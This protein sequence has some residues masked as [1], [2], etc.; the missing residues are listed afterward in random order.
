MNKLMPSTDFEAPP[1]GRAK[2][3]MPG[4]WALTGL[5]GI[6]FVTC[7]VFY[8]WLYIQQVQNGYRLAKL[9]DEH[10]ELLSVQRKLYL[11]WSRFQDPFQLEELGQ[12]EYGLAPPKQDQKLV[13]R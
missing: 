2:R 11:E 3:G 10:Q 12:K 5:L 13:T 8:I 6:V 1:Q 7:S 4:W 9:Y